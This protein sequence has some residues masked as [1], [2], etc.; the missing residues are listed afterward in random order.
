MSIFGKIQHLRNKINPHNDVSSFLQASPNEQDFNSYVQEHLDKMTSNLSKQKLLDYTCHAYPHNDT[1][2]S[3][4]LN[5][6]N[7]KSDEKEEHIIGVADVG[8]HIEYDRWTSPISIVPLVLQSTLYIYAKNESENIDYADKLSTILIHRLKEESIDLRTLPTTA[9][10]EAY[11]MSQ[12]TFTNTLKEDP[13]I[14]PSAQFIQFKD[15]YERMM[16]EYSLDDNIKNKNKF[17]A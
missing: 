10:E 9:S 13:E 11:Y 14:I 2:Y 8:S 4:I 12:G 3:Q 6:I 16:N 5:Q 7:L 17:K 15:K 1:L